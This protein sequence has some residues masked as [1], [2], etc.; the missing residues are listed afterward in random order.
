MARGVQDMS[1]SLVPTLSK[2][3]PRQ[4]P[5]FAGEPCFLTDSQ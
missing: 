2:V 5:Y 1:R 3:V 4:L